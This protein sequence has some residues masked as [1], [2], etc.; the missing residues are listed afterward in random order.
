MLRSVHSPRGGQYP[1]GG[2]S[3]GL[4]LDRFQ[5][6]RDGGVVDRGG[7]GVDVAVRDDPEARCERAEPVP[8]LGSVEKP[9]MV[10]TPVEA[11]VRDDDRGG[12]RHALRPALPAAHLDRGLHGFGAAVH[13]Q[14]EVHAR[15]VGQLGAEGPSWSW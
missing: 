3:T 14:D 12:C 15:Q 10:V 13:R 11:A 1:G 8:C 2:T 5:Q 7:K 4:A 6:Q 9:T